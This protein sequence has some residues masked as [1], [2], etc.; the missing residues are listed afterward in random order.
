MLPSNQ[1]LFAL[2]A[3]Q[4]QREPASLRMLQRLWSV[5]WQHDVTGK[6]NCHSHSCFCNSHL[7]WQEQQ[8]SRSKIQ[9]KQTF[10][11]KPIFSETHTEKLAHE[12]T[13][14]VTL[15]ACFVVVVVVSYYEVVRLLPLRCPI[16]HTWILDAECNTCPHTSP[17]LMISRTCTSAA[18]LINT[19]R[20]FIGTNQ[21]HCH[22]V[23]TKVSSFHDYK[24]IT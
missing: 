4:M 5:Q 21:K 20:R 23:K 13:H 9:P 16:C 19:R 7:Y 18:V 15:L 2:E 22:F 3:S 8:K 6:Y 10:T 11:E 1:L 12:E 17:F 14:L 24:D